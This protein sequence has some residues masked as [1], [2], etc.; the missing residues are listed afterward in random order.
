MKIVSIKPISYN[1][2]G[3]RITKAV[4][5]EFEVPSSIGE[6]LVARGDAKEIEA[7]VA[8]KPRAVKQKKVEQI[9]DVVAEPEI[10]IEDEV[11]EHAISS[12]L[13]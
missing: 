6:F 2:N 11:S 1:F 12:E 3:A 9:E 5:I 7:V 13:E 10:Q 4:G 8:E